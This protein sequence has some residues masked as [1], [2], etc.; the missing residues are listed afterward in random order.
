MDLENIDFKVGSVNPSGIKDVVYFIPKSHITGWPT[1]VDDFD[2]A[3][4]ADDYVELDG[5]FTL[6]TGKK[7]HKLYNT[8]GKGK[9][10]WGRMFR[11]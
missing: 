5:N 6:A 10:N 2:D 3:E 8:Q 9:I 1:I 4:D 7:F 11:L